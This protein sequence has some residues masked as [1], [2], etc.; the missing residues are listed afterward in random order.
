MA[1]I[2]VKVGSVT[3]AQKAKR[4]LLKKG[5]RAAVKRTSQIKKGDG[6]GY[7]IVTQGDSGTVLSILKQ[8]GINTVS[9]ASNDIFR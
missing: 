6:C 7:S 1:E 4:I 3:N 8:A 9:V 5:Y 2:T